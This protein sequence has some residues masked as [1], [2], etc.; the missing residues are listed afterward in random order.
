MDIP[1]WEILNVKLCFGLAKEWD[2]S[3]LDEWPLEATEYEKL[4]RLQRES[5]YENIPAGTTDASADSVLEHVQDALRGLQEWAQDTVRW[6]GYLTQCVNHSYDSV[7]KR[8]VVTQKLNPNPSNLDILNYLAKANRT[9]RQRPSLISWQ[10][11]VVH[12]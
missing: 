4:V 9:I 8:H 6:A 2:Q 7:L 1:K 3:I 5:V 11:C 10:L 12:V